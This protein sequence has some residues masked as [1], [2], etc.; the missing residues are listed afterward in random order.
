MGDRVTWLIPILNGMPYLT[1]TLASIEA[2]TYTNWEVL[3]W[4][5]GSTDGTIEELEKWIPS[6]L[7]GRVI[8]G[9]PHSVG[10]ALAEMVKICNTDICARIDADDINLPDRLEKQLHY[11]ADHPEI[12]VLGSWMYFIDK[13]SRL[14]QNLYKVPLEH[15]DIVHRMLTSNAI[16]HP[17]VVFRRSAV[18]NVG[19]YRD[20]PNIEDL[21]LWLRILQKYKLAN[22]DIPLVKYRIHENSTTNIAMKENRLK[23]A[24]D[25][26][27]C[28]NAPLAFGCSE[29]EMRLLR[30]QK[31]SFAI[32]PIL[33]IA[34]YLQQNQGGNL[35]NRLK[36]SS[37]INNIKDLISSK[38]ILSLLFFAFWH[39]DRLFL[40]HE[41]RNRLKT[42]AR[43]SR[44]LKIFL[45]VYRSY[46]Y[47]I[48]RKNYEK[49]LAQWFKNLELNGCSVHQSIEFFGVAEPFDYI[50]IAE[51]CKI[52]RDFTLW[53]SPDDGADAKF[54]MKKRSYIGRNT[55][56]GVFQPISI[57]ECSMIGAYSYIISANHNYEERGTPIRDQGYTGKPIVIEDDVWLGT[58]VVVLPGV[59][60]G[61]GAIVAAHSLVNRSIPAY[62]VWGGVPVRFIKH[63]PQ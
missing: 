36:Y 26:C 17:S 11:L 53:L 62:E 35:N 18:L 20:R 59:T 49:E 9:S 47:Y 12:S 31:H 5:N 52:D 39:P 48:D 6:R 3:V 2:Q 24:M 8:T 34:K 16:P 32:M 63:R 43:K 1:E 46:R 23:K 19:N 30:E 14:K 42:S 33:K 7:A 4:D 45:D 13:K 56:I 37:F 61:K 27:A 58:H 41:L 22:L 15:D 21:D 44:N 28:T 57:G 29:T 10:G 55:Y 40:Y 54:V 38:D 25:D 50:D 51:R 60:I